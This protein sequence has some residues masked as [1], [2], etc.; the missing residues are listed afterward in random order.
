MKTNER[1]RDY[2]NRFFE[3]CNTCVGV[4]DDQVVDSYKKGIRDRKVF[5]KIHESGATIVA[6][7]IEVVNKLIDT[8]E[9]LVNQFDFDAK[10][11]V[12]TSGAVTDPSS[13][14]RK[15]PSEVLAAE[16]RHTSTFNVEEFNAV[17]DSPCTFH[18]G[19]THTVR[20]C[21][22]FKRAF[23]TPDDPKRSRGDDNWSSS[24]RYNN[25]RRDD[26]RGR[27]DDGHRDDR[28]CDE[29]QLQERRDER[30][31]PP[32]PATGNRN[33]PIQQAKRSINMI[34]GGL[35]TS[36][37]NRRY[38]KDKCEI[39]LIH[40]K[41]SQPLRWSEQPSQPLGPYPRSRVLPPRCRA[42]S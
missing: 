18:E 6:T 5:E 16:G 28:R 9:A 22:Q 40:T 35:K 8:D 15:R 11:N 10:C 20:E 26:R 38:R 3:N 2:T 32:P 25:N 42:N 36:T 14:L 21:S 27:G 30:D 13:K 39:Q 33:D 17:L 34:I 12:G 4:Q 24:H 19:A 41:P 23:R 1:H 29:Q 7:L 37:S 31:L